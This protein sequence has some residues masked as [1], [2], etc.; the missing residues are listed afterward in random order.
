MSSDKST[1]EANISYIIPWNLFVNTLKQFLWK[2]IK[3]WK[4]KK[5]YRNFVSSRIDFSSGGNIVDKN[6]N[7]IGTHEGV[8]QFTVGQRKGIPGGQGQAK[9]VTKID[10]ENN[11]VFIGSK[12]DLT[13]KKFI[14]EDVSFVNGEEYENLSIQTR[15]NSHDIPCKLKKIDSSTYEIELDQATLGVAPGQFG[16]IY[17]DTKL[18]GGGR[19]SSKILENVNEWR[20]RK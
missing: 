20:V 10:V 2:E 14:I 15:Y 9:Y 11:K 6:N 19:I 16:V 1:N 12:A 18:I 4:N 5:D 7:V 17:N 8:H 13:T 3:I